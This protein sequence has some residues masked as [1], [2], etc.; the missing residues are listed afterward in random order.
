MRR[1][2]RSC[3]ISVRRLV[4]SLVEPVADTGQ[5][6][7]DTAAVDNRR[8]RPDTRV[9]DKRR[10]RQVTVLSL[11]HHRR[12]RLRRPAVDTVNRNLVTVRV[13]NCQLTNAGA[14]A[15]K[16]QWDRRVHPALTEPM[17]KTAKTEGPAGMAGTANRLGVES[18]VKPEPPPVAELKE[19]LLALEGLLEEPLEELLEEP[20][21][22]LPLELEITA[23][24]RRPLLTL[25]HR[26]LN[27]QHHHLTITI[28]RSQ[29]KSAHRHAN[30]DRLVKMD[31]WDKKARQDQRVPRVQRAPMANE[32]NV[33]WLDTK[34]A[35]VLLENRDRK[36]PKETMEKLIIS[37]D[38]LDH[39]AQLEKT[40]QGALPVHPERTAILDRKANRAML[41]TPV[42]QDPLTNPAVQVHLVTR[43]HLVVTAVATIVHHRVRRRAIK[44]RPTMAM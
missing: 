29:W 31:R 40:V 17:V 12:L 3:R 9:V 22:L 10:R 19:E 6:R 4:D 32:E 8:R 18:R 26:R 43:V 25:H 27:R 20:Q 11:H 23:Q 42:S 5:R 15:D 39:L 34:L 33:V 38:P 7:P 37:M 13:G 16:D 1:N 14:R 35:P 36:D 21:V 28:T 24:P 30:P 44:I 2:P 41:E